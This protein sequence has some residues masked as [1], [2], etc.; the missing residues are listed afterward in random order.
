[1][2]VGYTEVFPKNLFYMERQL[3]KNIGIFLLVSNT[4]GV[5]ALLETIIFR[6]PFAT[7]FLVLFAFLAYIN[8]RFFKRESIFRKNLD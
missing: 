5:F 2:E 3:W 7:I 6:F 8:L 4:L 1:M